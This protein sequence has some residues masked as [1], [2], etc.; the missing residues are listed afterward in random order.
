G[1]SFFGPLR[2]RGP[3]FSALFGGKRAKKAWPSYPSDLVTILSLPRHFLQAFL[4]PLAEHES[5]HRRDWWTGWRRRRG[6]GRSR[7]NARQSWPRPCRRGRESS[8]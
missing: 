5:W 6:D 7:R 2:V 3:R 1:P 8:P 4:A